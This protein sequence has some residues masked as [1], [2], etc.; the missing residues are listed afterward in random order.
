MSELDFT[1]TKEIWKGI[2][3]YE[4]LYLISNL[5]R[6]ISTRN[7]MKELEDSPF[8]NGKILKLNKRKDGY[9]WISL[10][11]KGH[12]IQRLVHRLVL[13]TFVGPSP[14]NKNVCRHLDGDPSNNRLDNLMWGTDVENALDRK[15]HGCTTDGEDSHLSKLSRLDVEMIRDLWATGKYKQVEIGKPF[16]VK[17]NAV[18]HIIRCATWK[19]TYAS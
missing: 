18:S 16:G 15:R 19:P 4:K 5:G 17:Q 13:E 7:T 1:D 2:T 11:R 10:Y 3:N 14:D 8:G 12:M 6:I 9:R